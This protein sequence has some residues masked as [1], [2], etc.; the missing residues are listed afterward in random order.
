MLELNVYG[1]APVRLK[2]L[3][4]HFRAGDMTLDAVSKSLWAVQHVAGLSRVIEVPPPY[5]KVIERA[6]FPYGTDLY[7][8]DISPD[9]K[10]IVAVIADS[11][12]TQQVALLSVDA[13]RAGKRDFETVKD[14]GFSSAAGF[15]FSPDGKKVYGT[16][17]YSGASNIFSLDV[18][19]KAME[20]LSNTETGLF[21]PRKLAD[22]R[23]I[24]YEYTSKGFYP[25]EVLNRAPLDDVSAVPYFGQEIVKKYPVV[26]SWK[27]ASAE[28]V[29]VM[30]STT[31]AGEFKPV[32][33][34]RPSSIYPIIQGYKDTVA[35]GGRM[36]FT[37]GLGLA[38]L[39]LTAAYSPRSTEKAHASLDFH[40][41]GWRV[42]AAYNNADFY[43]LFGPTKVSRKGF[44]GLVGQK[45]ILK[46]SSSRTL[47]FDWSLAGYAG[48][49]RLPDFQNVAANYDKFLTGRAFVEYKRLVKTLG[50]VEE[51]KGTRW[52]IVTQQNIVNGAVYP[53]IYGQLDQG[54]LTPIRNSPV[55]IRSSAGK[56]FG[57]RDQPFANFY[58]GGFGN[59]RIDHQEV[60]RYREYYAFPGVKLNQIGATDYL[61]SL[62]EWNL[63]PKRFRSFG[64]SYLYC[65]WARVSL[66]S[67]V[68][69]GNLASAQNRQVVGNAGAQLDMKVVI[70][71]Y[72]NTTFSVGLAGAQDRTG[73][74]SSEVMVS[75][76]LQ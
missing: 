75:L 10:R 27:V 37:D 71:S 54:F 53:R 45:K 15:T 59:N 44:A 14:F 7:D 64:T 28:S 47:D 31:R 23:L 8:L 20:V 4:E 49:E 39:R 63:P 22:G 76:K 48:L 11:S 2:K 9:G 72:L 24:A 21:Y 66:F 51:E 73:R 56:S 34:L 55:W 42:R 68:I 26:K 12:G 43:D 62:V 30:K 38:S 40:N 74:R 61:K 65:N 36:D 67:G 1:I 57:D 6:V 60:S 33:W 25:V 70:A 3:I 19:T 58:F 18:E 29:D 32:R 41:F 16:S 46:Y 50:A 52:K 69:G 35:Y 13:L 5:D 17:Y